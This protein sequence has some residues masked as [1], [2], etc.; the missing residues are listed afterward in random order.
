MSRACQEPVTHLRPV[1]HLR[2]LLLASNPPD[3]HGIR[4]LTRAQRALLQSMGNA[5][6]PA[7]E[8]AIAQAAHP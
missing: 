4:T 3:K 1:R 7:I 8:R 5:P 6:K 2:A